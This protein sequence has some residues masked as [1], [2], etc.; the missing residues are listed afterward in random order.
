M[1]KSLKTN[2]SVWTK[3]FRRLVQQLKTDPEFKRVVGI[4]NLRSW[5]GVAGDKDPFA[6]PG[7]KPVVRLTPQPRG[8]DWYSED[9][10]AGTLYVLVEM[11]VQSLCIDD[12]ADLY[13]L[14][15]AALRPG[16][17]S[18]MQELIALGAE[19]GEIVFSDPAF[20]P[21]PGTDAEGY[22]L[23]SGHFQLKLIR[24]VNP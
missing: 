6:A 18:L 5:E 3:V 1:P 11:C 24:S 21:Q 4:E 19:T 9:S 14:V 7:A 15:V 2:Q 20:D 10:Q 23:A 22:F 16:N 8:V 12:V 13:D 17:G